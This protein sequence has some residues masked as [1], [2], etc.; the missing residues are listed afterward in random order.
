M[1]M[2][3]AFVSVVPL[4]LALTAGA[5]TI[6][7]AGG[8][9]TGSTQGGVTG[10][11][12]CCDQ[13]SHDH[14]AAVFSWTPT[15]P[16]F[17]TI[18][19][20]GGS[21]TNLSTPQ[22]FFPAV[23][24][25]TAPVGGTTLV[26]GRAQPPSATAEIRVQATPE[27]VTAGM[28]FY[29]FVDASSAMD[30]Y[31][32]VAGAFTLSLEVGTTAGSADLW[33]MPSAPISNLTRLRYRF[34][35]VDN[36]TQVDCAGPTWKIVFGFHNFVGPSSTAFFEANTYSWSRTFQEPATCGASIVEASAQATMEFSIQ[37]LENRRVGSRTV[38]AAFFPES[39]DIIDTFQQYWKLKHVSQANL[40]G[41]EE[42]VLVERVGLTSEVTG[43]NCRGDLQPPGSRYIW[44]QTLTR[45]DG[46]P[47]SAEFSVPAE[48]GQY[49]D[50]LRMTDLYTEAFYINHGLFRAYYWGF[51]V[52]QEGSSTW[53]PLQQWVQ[54]YT[55]A[56]PALNT[57]GM[58]R[59]W[60]Q[61][62]AV[63]EV[64]NDNTPTYLRQNDTLDLSY[65]PCSPAPM[66][67]C[68]SPSTSTFHYVIS[69]DGPAKNK[70][71]WSWK[72]R[73]G[74]PALSFGDPRA[75]TSYALCLYDQT[76]GGLS[77]VTTATAPAAGTCKNKPC[78]S[79]SSLLKL[80][81]KDPDGTPDGVAKVSLKAS[82]N[83]GGAIKVTGQG[84]NLPLPSAQLTLPA[85]LQLQ[86]ND[87]SCF[88]ADFG[89]RVVRNDP[90]GFSGRADV[91]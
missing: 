61:G 73:S 74:S 64:S 67:A 3:R 49:F 51:E 45:P 75:A 76:P 89:T 68:T 7:P 33:P 43:W 10:T 50:P 26:C 46:I 34:K 16:G 11:S 47:H 15:A 86:S 20:T 5:Q 17:A 53:V 66:P 30:P 29:V 85:T 91:P 56:T 12:A 60:Y 84:V 2:L 88:T 37:D 24:V 59:G 83:G 87:G 80:L 41:E 19:V 22:T 39:T 25:T 70:L 9:L 62:H 81:Y 69:A 54:H 21:T 79:G 72:A 27:E 78:W 13:T 6:P 31:G 8:T 38:D 65:T 28:T 1:G 57:W 35:V 36:Q 44:R 90:T 55:D 58:K 18:R 77:P 52:Q 82:A 4:L 71:T 32:L 48:G 63:I 23:Y 40:N 14:P 42:S